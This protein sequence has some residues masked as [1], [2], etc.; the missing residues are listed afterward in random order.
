MD[1]LSEETIKRA[2][3]QFL[4]TY[5]KFRPRGVG[6]TVVSTDMETST[7]VVADGYFSFPK[8]DGSPF[9]ATFEATSYEVAKEV[10]FSLRKQQLIWDSFAVGSGVS[11]LIIA[12]LWAYK[13][14]E[15]GAMGWTLSLF[16][17]FCIL[18]ISV[19][20]FQ[21]FFNTASRYRY[22][23][24]VEQFK[25]Y[26]ADEQWIAIGY[27]VFDD[28]EDVNLVELKSQC[29]ENGFGLLQVDKDEHLLMLISPAQEEVFAHRR[30]SFGFFN[31]PVSKTLQIDKLGNTIREAPRNFQ[32]FRRPFMAQAMICLAAAT[33]ISGVFYRQWQGR[34]MLYANELIRQ[35]S[36]SKKAKMMIGETGMD[37]LAEDGALA[38]RSNGA[39][40][41]NTDGLEQNYSGVS[42][43]EVGL[44][45]YT[46]EGYI[47]YDCSRADIQGTKYIV[48]DWECSNF[49][50]ARDR[51]NQLKRYGLIANCISL[52]CSVNAKSGY[53]VYYE[54][55]YN[56]QK[57]ANQKA[58]KIIQE[59][60][61]LHVPSDMIKIRRLHAE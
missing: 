1:Y 20:A 8:E 27:D 5:Y 48:Q 46:N 53:A 6:E 7:G 11:A 32:R 28:A 49:E 54:F 47:A 9:I 57:A 3:L 55:M 26:H 21:Q 61:A 24:A 29:V 30:R 31:H 56:D 45:V 36:L 14:W 12:F 13:L 15:L 43:N 37:T 18:A 40:Y 42:K 10:R 22:I 51:I 17:V 44:Y 58:L 2:T 25:Q 16:L 33:V 4:K 38:Y 41:I 50:E 23:F 19:F 35:D 59:L 52:K 34:P 39:T 60:K